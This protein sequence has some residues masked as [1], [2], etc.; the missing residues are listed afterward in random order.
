MKNQFPPPG[1][2]SDLEL[3]LEIK[4]LLRRE[5]TLDPEVDRDLYDKR[6]RA[7]YNAFI[8]RESLGGIVL[9]LLRMLRGYGQWV[10][11]S[12]EGYGLVMYHLA[13]FH[14]DPH[15]ARDRPL[16]EM[17]NNAPIDSFD[18]NYPDVNLSGWLGVTLYNFF[19]GHIEKIDRR[20]GGDDNGRRTVEIPH[21]DDGDPLPSFESKAAWLEAAPGI[22]LDPSRHYIQTIDL[23]KAVRG[24]ALYL[25]LPEVTD[26]IE[27]QERFNA[28]VKL[29]YGLLSCFKEDLG[30]SDSGIY[31]AEV[32]QQVYVPEAETSGGRISGPAPRGRK[33]ERYNRLHD[34]LPG[35][36]RVPTIRQWARRGIERLTR[37]VEDQFQDSD[38][39]LPLIDYVLGRHDT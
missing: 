12:V 36:P 32:V 5:T 31:Y 18:P 4:A 29:V 13:G 35:A 6:F 34:Q 24:A 8:S 7:L 16:R 10:P 15:H 3:L 22:R 20:T 21:S 33:T 17:V 37:L 38:L 39:L 11:T 23:D 30:K 25:D 28:C 1:D 14:S 27:S 26:L 19:I 2:L 9:Y